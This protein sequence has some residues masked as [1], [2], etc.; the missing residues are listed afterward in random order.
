MSSQPKR[1]SANKNWVNIHMDGDK[2]ISSVDW[3][4][5]SSW[6]EVES[7]KSTV[8]LSCTEKLK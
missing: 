7:N 5:I 3:T 2:T 6:E 8:Y 1:T 4:K